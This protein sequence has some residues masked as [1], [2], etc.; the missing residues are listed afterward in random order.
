M[1]VNY[2][3]NFKSIMFTPLFQFYFI[4][5][6]LMNI[7]VVLAVARVYEVGFLPFVPSLITIYQF[8]FY[9]LIEIT[10]MICICMQTVRSFKDNQFQLIRLH[11]RETSI[12][13]ML[14]QVVLNC[15]VCYLLQFLFLLFG[16]TLFHSFSFDLGTGYGNLIY[17]I[18]LI[19]RTFLFILVI[20]IVNSLLFYL[21]NDKLILLVDFLLFI[22]ISNYDFYFPMIKI[23]NEIQ[24]PL[25]IS[26]MFCYHNSNFILE[27]CITTG[28]LFFS[29]VLCYIL[30][31][32]TIRLNKKMIL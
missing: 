9:H 5:T 16:V 22:S 13:V 15:C 17:A 26:G 32:I 20:S 21:I 25:F 11:D 28:Y 1:K 27:L 19:I 18:F 30:Y 24:F 23:S 7:Y 6:S 31:Y 10:G 12:A 3:E 14:K 29:T 4:I 2:Y 8:P